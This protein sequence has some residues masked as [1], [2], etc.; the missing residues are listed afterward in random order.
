DSASAATNQPRADGLRGSSASATA[1]S[2][3]MVAGLHTNSTVRRRV[4]TAYQSP[5][6][7]A[8]ARAS[9]P[10]MASVG[11]EAELAALHEGLAPRSHQRAQPIAPVLADRVPRLGGQLVG[12]GFDPGAVVPSRVGERSVVGQP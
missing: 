12:P 6:A 5:T 4:P 3:A 10:L 2:A 11:A 1:M 9:H 7:N 8:A